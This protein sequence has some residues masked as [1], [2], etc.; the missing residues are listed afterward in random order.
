MEKSLEMSV[1]GRVGLIPPLPLKK[2]KDDDKFAGRSGSQSVM[3]KSGKPIL[4]N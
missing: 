2:F 1:E 4:K 3:Q